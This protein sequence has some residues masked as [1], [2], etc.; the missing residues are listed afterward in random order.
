MLWENLTLVTFSFDVFS[1][2]I[3]S[4]NFV[5]L[6]MSKTCINTHNWNFMQGVACLGFTIYIQGLIMKQNGPV[7]VTTFNPLSTILVAILGSFILSKIMYL[8]RI[9]L[10]LL[11][12]MTQHFSTTINMTCW[13]CAWNVHSKYFVSFGT[14]IR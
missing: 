7:F 10:G 9:L 3:A 6:A 2:C 4:Y 12:P 1:L 14:F 8:G 11:N 13:H 5:R